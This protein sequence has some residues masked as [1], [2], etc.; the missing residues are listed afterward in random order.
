MT[1]PRHVCLFWTLAVIGLTADLGSKYWV[2]NALHGPAGR[3]EAD[4]IPGAFK[5]LA[6]FTSTPVS[7][8]GVI[9]MLQRA[10]GETLPHVNTGALFGLGSRANILF[11][12]ISVAAAG[13]IVFWSTRRTALTDRWLSM[14]L[15]LILAGTLGNLFD[16]IVFN[17]VRD[18]LY[19][20]YIVDWPVFNIAD[21][22]L[23]CGA[24]LLLVQ[25]MLYS[26]ASTPAPVQ[27]EAQ[28]AELK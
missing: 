22:C 28:C 7:N 26:P 21:C 15:G 5:L 1:Q 10:N 11:A 4:I 13:A 23:V 27:A 2:F 9:G 17:G 12:F 8:E 6:Q 3:G 19:W 25:A 14:A 24:G 18:F 20:Y 16:R